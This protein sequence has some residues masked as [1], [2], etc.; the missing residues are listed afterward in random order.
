[1]MNSRDEQFHPERVEEQINQPGQIMPQST[2]NAAPNVRMIQDLRTISTDYTQSGERVWSRL[3]ER[4]AQQNE[5]PSTLGLRTRERFPQERTRMVQSHHTTDHSIG[6][7]IS[8]RVHL[9]AATLVAALLVGTLVIVLALGHNHQSN[10]VAARKTATATIAPV[11]TATSSPAGSVV[12]TRSSDTGMNLFP[13]AAWSP[14]SKRI[15][16]LAVNLHSLQSQL[17]IWDATTGGDLLTVPLADNLNEVLWSPTGKYLAL[18]NLQT[19]VI[20]DSQTGS[21]VNTINFNT[22]T[23]SSPSVTGMSLLSSLMPHAGGSGF[24]SVAWT[25]DGTSLAV[26]VSYGTYGKVELMNPV[27]SAVNVTFSAHASTIS[28][29]LSFSTDGQY[30]A[31]TYPNDSRIVVWKVSTQAIAF[32]QDDVQAETI[33]WQPGTHHLAR[34]VLFPASVQ[35]WDITSKKLVKTYPGITSFVWSPDGKELATYTSH[36]YPNGL[37]NTKANQVVIID[38]TSGVQVALYT[39]QHL[40]IYAVS[41][42]PDGRYLVSAEPGST[43]NQILVWIA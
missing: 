24:Y 36:V 13:S 12:Y 1:M 40:S 41:W 8:R 7:T 18:N 4:V 10:T 20:V 22:T 31:V 14:D 17:Q 11:A 30:L 3:A 29:A 37:P 2:G 9:L 33:S 26:A 35:L 38:A 5:A 42:S 16:T 25:P 15:A 27:T 23:A 34:A 39:S 21:I 6:G 28:T 32:Q 19:I 43:G